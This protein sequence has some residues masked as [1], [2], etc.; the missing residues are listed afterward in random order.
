[1]LELSTS[2]T[3]VHLAIAAADAQTL[4]VL[5]EL[6]DPDHPV[7]SLSVAKFA[8]YLQRSGTWSYVS[9]SKTVGAVGKLRDFYCLVRQR[10]PIGAGGLKTLLEDFLY[11]YDNGTVL[12]WRPASN[13]QYLIARRAVCDYVKFVMDN[14][15]AP[16]GAVDSQFVSACRESWISLSHAQKSLLFHTKE[17]SRKKTGGR[18]RIISGLKQFKQFPP[19]LVQELIDETINPRDKLLFSML[20]Y[21]GRRTSEMLHLFMEDVQAKRDELLVSLKHPSFSNMTWLNKAHNRLRGQRREYLQSMFNLLPRQEHGALPT[22]AGW[23]GVKF[24][25]EAAMTSQLYWIKD[26]GKYM[27]KLHQDYLHGVRAN[28]KGR[29]PYYFVAQDGE[30]LTTRALEKQFRLACQ[31]IENK[32]GVSLRGYGLHSLRHFYGFY[33]ASVLNLSPLLIQKYM[34]HMSITSTLVY[35]HISPAIAEQ[36]LSQAERSANVEMASELGHDDCAKDAE[37]F[38]ELGR[39]SKHHVEHLGAAAFGVVDTKRLQRKLR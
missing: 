38:C 4:P 29:H 26:A 7:I 32:H 34:G 36:L 16:W 12:D 14:G 33:C 10:R 2:H 22:F 18:K 3:V 8:R 23:K 5:V 21:G 6:D 15:P 25:D 13:Q 1:M 28:S 37:K 9:I 19:H 17:R 24:D 20:A 35:T 30:P 39:R 31:R 11:A 27:L